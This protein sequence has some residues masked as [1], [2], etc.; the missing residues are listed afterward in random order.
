MKRAGLQPGQRLQL[1]PAKRLQVLPVGRVPPMGQRGWP[2]PL[3]LEAC[4]CSTN[5]GGS[6]PLNHDDFRVCIACIVSLSIIYIYTPLKTPVVKSRASSTCHRSLIFVTVDVGFPPSRDPSHHPKSWNVKVRPSGHVG[7]RPS[8]PPL[9][10]FKL[11]PLWVNPY[12]SHSGDQKVILCFLVPGC[13]SKAIWRCR[14]RPGLHLH[15]MDP[16]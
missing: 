9:P 3:E 14:D 6:A 2:G 11:W 4:F 13:K 16:F 15:G 7:K 8:N 1:R 5:R 12:E 10:I